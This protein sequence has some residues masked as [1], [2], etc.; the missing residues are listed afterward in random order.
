MSV[1]ALLSRLENVRQ[2]GKDRW[3]A[4]CPVHGGNNR[5]ALSIHETADG[6]VLMRCFVCEG[7]AIA[8]CEAIGLDPTELFPKSDRGRPIKKPS[9]SSD[10]LM[11]LLKDLRTV[12]VM[13]GD[14][15]R[16]TLKQV[17]VTKA[18][19]IQARVGRLIGELDRSV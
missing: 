11:A 2:A 13:V 6:V 8:V 17:D 3:R 14:M 10:V 18:K 16:G 19:E 7:N 9:R 4:K 12:Y 1:D 5:Y 15:A